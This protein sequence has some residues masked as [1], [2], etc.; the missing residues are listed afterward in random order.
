MDGRAST[1][2]T[3][4]VEARRFL[5]YLAVGALA[6]SV[7]YALLIAAVEWGRWPAW[8]ASGAAAVIGAQLGYFG[9]RSVTF[10]HQG[11]VAQSWRRFQ[12]TAL[13]GAGISMLVVALA[14]HWGLHYL[15]GQLLATAL[16]VLLTYAIN[17]RWTF[18]TKPDRA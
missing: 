14:V 1:A 15:L 13:F 10:S 6:T 18:G 7:H 8:L 11:P 9:N 12:I 17:R 16:A 2:R 3:A 5:A 4:R